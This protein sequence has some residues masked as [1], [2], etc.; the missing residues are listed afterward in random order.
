MFDSHCHLADIQFNTDR[1]KII[2]DALSDNINWM[3]CICCSQAELDTFYDLN[4]VYKHIYPSIGIHPHEAKSGLP[5]WI[6]E[7]I[8][9]VVAIGEI[10]LDYH[11]LFSPKEQQIDV[12]RNQIRIAK[13]N[14]LPVIIHAR[15]A[16]PDTIQILKEE[17]VNTGVI[18]CF[19]GNEQELKIF[20]DLG[21]YISFAGYITFPKSIES[22][23]LVELVPQDR[24]L[25]ET[26]APYLAPQPVRGK[27]NEPKYLRYTIEETAKIR[28]LSADRISEIILEN[29]R[30][31]FGI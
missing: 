31:L 16:I 19:S 3:L 26:D 10:G 12:F 15:E 14:N 4:K 30:R 11:Y 21:F 1:A 25:L 6:K 7:N 9:Q 27:R 5:D 28:N 13:Q 22:R 24:L 20:L 17:S 2:K 29:S 23:K 18:H 8:S